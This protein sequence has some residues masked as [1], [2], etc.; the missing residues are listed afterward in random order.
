[1]IVGSALASLSGLMADRSWLPRKTNAAATLCSYAQSWLDLSALGTDV[2]LVLLAYPGARM[3]SSRKQ[4]K[5]GT[6]RG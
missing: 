6:D 3:Q 4:M 5:E 2:P 1:M